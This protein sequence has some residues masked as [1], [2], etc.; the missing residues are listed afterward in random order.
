MFSLWKT[1]SNLEYI[2]YLDYNNI[3]WCMML[4][5]SQMMRTTSDTSSVITSEYMEDHSKDGTSFVKWVNI[6]WIHSIIVIQ[7]IQQLFQQPKKPFHGSLSKFGLSRPS[8]FFQFVKISLLTHSRLS[9][10]YCK[11]TSILFIIKVKRSL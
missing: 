3:W 1:F 2:D 11:S 9:Q 8:I 5:V 4:Y 6:F 7:A 10:Y